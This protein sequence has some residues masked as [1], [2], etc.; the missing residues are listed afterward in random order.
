M[1]LFLFFKDKEYFE[2]VVRPYIQ[3]KLYKGLID[4]FLLDEPTKDLF[5]FE[6]N[7]YD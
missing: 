7:E 4:K 3:N 6:S 5:T 1:N 2:K